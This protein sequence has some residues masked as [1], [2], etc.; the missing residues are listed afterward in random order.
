MIELHVLASGDRA[1]YEAGSI[2]VVA[3]ANGHALI[4]IDGLDVDVKETYEE[5]LNKVRAANK[6]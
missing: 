6:P 4:R 2:S 5:V 3:N 1:S